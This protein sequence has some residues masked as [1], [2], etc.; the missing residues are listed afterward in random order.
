MIYRIIGAARRWRITEEGGWEEYDGPLMG[1]MYA[2]LGEMGD[3]PLPPHPVNPRVRFWFTEQGWQDYGR[4]I[5]AQA[6]E[7]GRVFRLLMEKDPP[8]SRVAYKDQWQLALLPPD[9]KRKT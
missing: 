8:A 7:R 9:K 1:A 2:N 6:R 4:H 5:I 3:L